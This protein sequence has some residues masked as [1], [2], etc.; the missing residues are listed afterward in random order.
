MN[1][2]VIYSAQGVHNTKANYVLA[3]RH[4][5]KAILSVKLFSTSKCATKIINVLV[6]LSASLYNYFLS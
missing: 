4:Y 3:K 1:L 2:L 6:A 5:C